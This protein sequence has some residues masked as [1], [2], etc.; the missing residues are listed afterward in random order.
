MRLLI[1]PTQSQ[2][3]SSPGICYLPLP[4]LVRKFACLVDCH[5]LGM[6][7]PMK[8]LIINANIP[9]SVAV[10]LFV[11]RVFV[12]PQLRVVWA[13]EWP[14]IQ[15]L[16]FLHLHRCRRCLQKSKAKQTKVCLLR[17]HL[18]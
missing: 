9:Q 18:I 11:L 6:S 3:Q 4:D 5:V 15:I 2:S 16:E 8:S 17:E 12:A 13:F 14:L 10:C 7:P 1:S